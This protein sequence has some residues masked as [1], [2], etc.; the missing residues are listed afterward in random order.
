VN[1]MSDEWKR[2]SA[3]FRGRD[4][5]VIKNKDDW[6]IRNARANQGKSAGFR[7]ISLYRSFCLW[8]RQCLLCTWIM[9]WD[10]NS[11]CWAQ[12]ASLNAIPFYRF[13]VSLN[14]KV[15]GPVRLELTQTSGCQ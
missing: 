13:P 9:L 14:A 5:S 8:I 15:E 11:Q 2:I 1:H 10:W 12:S 7:A 6:V 3:R 4:G